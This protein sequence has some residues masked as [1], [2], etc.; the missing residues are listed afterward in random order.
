[1]TVRDRG[2]K[3]AWIM[4]PPGES[5]GGAQNIFRFISTWS[6]PATRASI[7]LYHSADH[8][9]DAPYLKQLISANSVVSRIDA[10]DFH[11]YD[12]ACGIAP[13]L[14]ALFATGW[15]TAYPALRDP[16]PARRFYF[17]QDFEPAFYSV[18]S[19]H[20]LAEN[21]YRFGFHGITAGGWLADKLARASTGCGR[22]RSA[23]APTCCT[24][25]CS[26]R[27]AGRSLLL[28]A[29]G[30]HPARVR[31]RASW[32]CS[33]WPARMPDRTIHL[34]GWDTSV[35]DLPFGTSTTR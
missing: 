8:P 20:V 26:M 15:E 18:G 7:Y 33:T 31:A 3:T 2:I 16:S 10:A 4:H 30:Y 6:R 35:Y 27:S 12:A 13:R 29:A 11:A 1:M 14:D 24:T 21:T 28:R 23:S 9:I 5:S 22:S 19:E 34:A 25:A 17:V 32:R